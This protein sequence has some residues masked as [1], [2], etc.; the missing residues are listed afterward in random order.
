MN[1]ETFSNQT[2]EA[3]FGADALKLCPQGVPDSVDTL[4]RFLEVLQT[5]QFYNVVWVNFAV[6]QMKRSSAQTNVTQTTSVFALAVADSVYRKE[7]GTVLWKQF[8]HPVSGEC[9][10]SRFFAC[11]L[12]HA[13]TK[14]DLLARL[15]FDLHDSNR[16]NSLQKDQLVELIVDHF[17]DSGR[18]G[19]LY[20]L[21]FMDLCLRQQNPRWTEKRRSATSETLR[22]RIFPLFEDLVAKLRAHLLLRATD[23]FKDLTQSMKPAITPHRGMTVEQFVPRFVAP[24]KRKI[25]FATAAQEIT[26]LMLHAANIANQTLQS[27]I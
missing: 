10:Q 27:F 15:L 13:L 18:F 23:C 17:T 21:F 12:A 3:L 25:Y 4:D 6:S 5:T 26:P 20:V 1:S 19:L 11:Y 9:S 2:L 8:R 14:W 24:E 22:Q 7:V 16:T